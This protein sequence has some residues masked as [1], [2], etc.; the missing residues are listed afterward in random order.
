MPGAPE[1]L[2][3]RNYLS[4][5]DW[6]F[7]ETAEDSLASIRRYFYVAN[8]WDISLRWSK[9][10]TPFWG[11]NSLILPYW[12][13]MPP[14]P[15]GPEEQARCWARHEIAGTIPTLRDVYFMKLSQG[16]WK[17][18]KSRISEKGYA[19]RRLN[20]IRRSIAKRVKLRAA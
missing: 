19:R 1:E 15:G 9:R 2:H 6:R 20:S 12:F 3:F 8:T 16:L 5:Q 13:R 7:L 18:S 17:L 10:R 11:A 14:F 4:T